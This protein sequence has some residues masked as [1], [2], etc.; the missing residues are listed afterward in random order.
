MAT[1]VSKLTVLELHRLAP[2]DFGQR[3]LG[4][5]VERVIIQAAGGPNRS[6]AGQTC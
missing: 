1:A 3:A 5:S 2:V 4:E 6:A